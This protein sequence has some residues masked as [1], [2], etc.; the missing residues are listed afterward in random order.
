MIILGRFRVAQDRLSEIEE[1][2]RKAIEEAKNQ[3]RAQQLAE[4]KLFE[5]G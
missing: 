3:E 4:L 2:K 1:R 5:E